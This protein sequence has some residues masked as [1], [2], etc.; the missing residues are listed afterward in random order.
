MYGPAQRHLPEDVGNAVCPAKTCSTD[1]GTPLV[2]AI[3]GP[4]R[5]QKSDNCRVQC[6]KIR[7]NIHLSEVS[8]THTTCLPRTF[9]K[10]DSERCFINYKLHILSNIYIILL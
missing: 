1:V 8:L 2:G 6:S 7:A 4:P 3:T 5:V 9:S 10:V